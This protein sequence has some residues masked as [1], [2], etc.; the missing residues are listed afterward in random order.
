MASTSADPLVYEAP[1][2]LK[3]LDGGKSGIN[4]EDI[5]V[6]ALSE[7]YVVVE[8]D[9][10]VADIFPE[11]EAP[12]PA[13]DGDDLDDDAGG[14]WSAIM[15]PDAPD[16]AAP[17]PAQEVVYADGGA[18]SW[19]WYVV[20]GKA[21]ATIRRGVNLNTPLVDELRRGTK[22]AVLDTPKSYAEDTTKGSVRCYLR[23]PLQGWCSLK[24]LAECEP[25]KDGEPLHKC[26][27]D[28]MGECSSDWVVGVVSDHVLPAPEQLNKDLPSDIRVLSSRPGRVHA[29][30][31]A[32]QRAFHY[33]LPLCWL[34]GAERAGAER[35][36]EGT[37]VEVGK[38]GVRRPAH[39]PRGDK[40]S[41]V[42]RRALRQLKTALR[43]AVQTTGAWHNFADPGL[44]GLL[45]PFA[46]A[47]CAEI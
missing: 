27:G 29:E 6:R 4:R 35:V 32:T 43:A 40:S 22:V 37:T 46:A 20:I 15:A 33:L 34:A 19:Q 16:A 25:P 21:G 23:K 2:W 9:A 3:E 5:K 41:D 39:A 7:T 18:G 17:A 30:S 14:L 10:G 1:A 45:S 12:G 42:T 24:L 26:D 13:T 31:S 11:L 44:R 47:T 28:S 36:A 8:G 38:F